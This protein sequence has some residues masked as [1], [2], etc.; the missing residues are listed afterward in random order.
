M[1]CFLRPDTLYFNIE[2]GNATVP[3]WKTPL[4]KK[5]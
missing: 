4:Y 5:Q 1:T 2:V 3:N